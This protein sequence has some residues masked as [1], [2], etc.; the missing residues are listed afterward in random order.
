MTRAHP[1]ARTHISH[2]SLTVSLG[3]V[4]AWSVWQWCRTRTREPCPDGQWFGVTCDGANVAAINLTHNNVV[5]TVPSS[6][7][8]IAT[9]I[10]LDLSYNSLSG[11]LPSSFCNLTLLESL[12]LSHNLLTSNLDPCLGQLSSIRILYADIAN[13]AAAIPALAY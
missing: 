4:G 7:G 1:H 6:F 2:A 5:G 12:N 3:A 13:A 8:A 9:L 10:D 11:A